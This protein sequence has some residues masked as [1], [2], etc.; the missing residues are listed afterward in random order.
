MMKNT[1]SPLLSGLFLFSSPLATNAIPLDAVSQLF[2][3]PANNPQT[4]MV[5]G[6]GKARQKAD[7]AVLELS[8]GAAT[9]TDEDTM[10]LSLTA[11]N[12][13][14][15]E[16]Q[17][18]KIIDALVAIGVNRTD[19]QVRC[20][21]SSSGGFPF[22][23]PFPSQSDDSQT[24]I[25]ITVENPSH[26]R[27]QQIL[28]TAG[29]AMGKE[30]SIDK[31]GVR[32]RVNDCQALQREAYRNAIKDA[33]NRASALAE[34]LEVQLNPVP[35]I[36]EPFYGVILPEGC[37]TG[38]NFWSDTTYN[39]SEAIEVQANKDIFATFSVR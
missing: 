35:S 20:P 6:K 26:P 4:F 17:A 28:T 15:Q 22:P 5:L 14:P 10:T 38:E 12:K 33:Q 1:I 3:P 21:Q 37:T 29:K 39:A 19:I 24:K 27:L 36:A 25:F 31:V 2:Y 32:Y 34:A 23:F 11:Q 9:L 18:E 13:T 8:L 30:Q 7:T 16:S